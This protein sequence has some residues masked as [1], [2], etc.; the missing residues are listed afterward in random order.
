MIF[1]VLAV[2]SLLASAATAASPCDVR[3]GFDGV[4]RTGSW[5]PLSITF[6]AGDPTPE[7]VCA[8]VEDPDGQYLRS[9]AAAVEADA[10]GTQTARVLVRFG[11]PSARV[12]I[13]DLATR[14]AAPA[15]TAVDRNLLTPVALPP[16]IPAT[17]IVMLVLG[18]LPAAERA[19]RLMARDDGTRPRVVG[20]DPAEVVGAAS[21]RVARSANLGRTARDFDGADAIVVCGRAVLTADPAVLQGLDGWVRQGGQLIFCAG[22]TA[23]EIDRGGTVAA[24]WLPGAVAKLVPLRR[25]SAIETFARASRPLD[26]ADVAGLE[27]PIFKAP[28]AILGNVEAFEGKGAADL[29]LA[30]RRPHGLGTVFWVG[31]D[32]DKPPFRNWSG[33]D[34]M[35]VEM[36]RGRRAAKDA[37]RSGETSR[38]TLDLAGQ[39]RQAIDHFPGVAPIPFEVI[40]GLGILYVVCL[41]P[42]DWWLASRLGRATSADRQRGRWLG[43]LSLP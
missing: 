3:V 6:P 2:A 8:W 31:V 33:S 21:S 28:Q 23:L 32:L 4:Y 25:A 1:L 40:A 42:L 11:R 10:D 5:T 14:G 13:E 35:L 29:P 22:S 39:L 27:V 16:P 36:L 18:D 43:W 26:K 20:I 15:V 41:Y 30:V 17:E 19:S 12:L 7:E 38:G 24:T 34:S 9:P 37:G